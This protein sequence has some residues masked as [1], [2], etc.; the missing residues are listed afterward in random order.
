MNYKKK[1]K[2]L[3]TWKNQW[4]T[5][6]ALSYLNWVYSVVWRGCHKR[7]IL[8]VRRNSDSFTGYGTAT[9]APSKAPVYI[10][11]QEVLHYLRGTLPFLHYHLLWGSLLSA[12]SPC[13]STP[14]TSFS[15]TPS[16]CLYSWRVP[17]HLTN[18]VEQ[19]LIWNLL[20][21]VSITADWLWHTHT[22]T[23]KGPVVRAELRYKLLAS[24][25]WRT[26]S[27]SWRRNTC[28]TPSCP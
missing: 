27:I 8:I 23:L 4:K 15:Q 20:T 21:S 9:A 19:N 22:H 13:V 25:P 17:L 6:L 7:G 14:T 5:N 28:H 11:T 2:N 26:T 12:H 18:S 3:K 24:I 10:S 16:D 1:K